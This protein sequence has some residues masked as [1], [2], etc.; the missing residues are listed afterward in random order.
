MPTPLAAYVVAQ[1]QAFVAAGW[2]VVAETP[3]VTL[4]NAP[5]TRLSLQGNLFQA[6]LKVHLYF[7]DL[8]DRKLT[9]TCSGNDP[10][11]LRLCQAS[12]LTLQTPN[13]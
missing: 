7:L 11:L 12:A 1:K 8:T 9:L 6:P 10:D 5:G 13:P 4:Q 3:F 2:Q